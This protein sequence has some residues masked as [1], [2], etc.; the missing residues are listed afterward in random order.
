MHSDVARVV[1]CG[2]KSRTLRFGES[3][4]SRVELIIVIL[5]ADSNTTI[6]IEL[7]L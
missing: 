4:T 1:V 6:L 3:A 2:G 7:E 5:V